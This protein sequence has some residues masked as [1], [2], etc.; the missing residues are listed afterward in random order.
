[1]KESVTAKWQKKR[2]RK[3]KIKEIKEYNRWPLLH[4]YRFPI[5][6]QRFFFRLY[7]YFCRDNYEYAMTKARMTTV[8]MT[9]NDHQ[10]KKK[11]LCVMSNCEK[12]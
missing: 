7:S 3:K 1:M 4:P 8:L 9:T 6:H 10:T 2:K 12:Y 5:E 11:K